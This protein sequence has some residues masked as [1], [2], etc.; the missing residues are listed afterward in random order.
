M[1]RGQDGQLRMG[2]E[3]RLLP[4]PHVK[5]L[6]PLSRTTIWRRIRDGRFPR[7]LQISPG[8]VAWVEA[9]ILTWIAQRQ[10]TL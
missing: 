2:N 5:Q 3:Q 8:R 1:G 9:E 4:W 7:P 6:I 10:R